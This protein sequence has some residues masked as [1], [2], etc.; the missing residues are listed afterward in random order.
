MANTVIFTG[1]A[2]PELA[3]KIA[4]AL[5]ERMGDM[6]IT[7][8]SDNE[9]HVTI[10]HSIR[11]QD[12]YLVQPTCNPCNH[13]LME[14]LIMIDA[15]KRSG[16]RSITAV[17]PYFGYARQDRR[18]GFSRVAISSAV[19]AKILQSVGV[20]CVITMDLHAQQLQGFFDCQLIDIT[21]KP[22][23]IPD[24]EQRF[25]SDL[26]IVSPDIGG[27]G[28]ARHIAKNLYC[29]DTE[30]AVVEKRRTKANECDVL[31]VIGNVEGRIC[32]MIDDIVD[33]AG[34]LCKAAD[35]L[36]DRGAKEVHAYCSHPVLSGKALDNIDNSRLFSLTV[37]DSIPLSRRA[38]DCQRIRVLS[39][40]HIIAD[41]IRRLR[42]S[43]SV[44]QLYRD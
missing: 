7:T 41:T 29:G 16:P 12:V 17:I 21:A 25:P 35:V 40:S 19:A 37:T 15:C 43:D 18:V 36:M 11:G 24:I 22:L 14:L 20:D 26:L 3:Q 23:F 31:S 2:H 8:F 38:A 42:T 39:C 33:T 32:V 1:S 4:S 27:A 5:S 9:T 30:L 10:N 13:H 28:R 44:S 34:T 6:D